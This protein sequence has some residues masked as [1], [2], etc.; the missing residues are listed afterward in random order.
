MNELEFMRL[1]IITLELESFHL[2]EMIT[3]PYAVMKVPVSTILSYLG[4][5]LHTEELTL[6]MKTDGLHFTLSE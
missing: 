6:V 4:Y 2:N 3:H 1:R 5:M